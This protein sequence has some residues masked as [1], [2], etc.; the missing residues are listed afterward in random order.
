MGRNP[1]DFLQH[2]SAAD[3]RTLQCLIGYTY[4]QE[5][6]FGVTSS[7]ASSTNRSGL[8][9]V[10][11]STES[12]LHFSITSDSWPNS[13]SLTEDNGM[14]SVVPPAHIQ[15]NFGRRQHQQDVIC[16]TF[17]RPKPAAV[18]TSPLSR[19]NS[20]VDQAIDELMRDLDSYMEIHW[21]AV[22]L[23]V[24]TQQKLADL[25]NSRDDL[26]R[27]GAGL[28]SCRQNEMN[29]DIEPQHRDAYYQA[30]ELGPIEDEYRTL[31]LSLYKIE[32]SLAV[33]NVAIQRKYRSIRPDYPKPLSEV[34]DHRSESH[35]SFQTSPPMSE[36]QILS[37]KSNRTSLLDAECPRERREICQSNLVASPVYS[38]VERM[39]SK[40]VHVDD[41][42][43]DPSP[44]LTYNS[45]DPEGARPS[46]TEVFEDFISRPDPGE[47]LPDKAKVL[48]LDDHQPLSISSDLG[49]TKQMIN[50]WLLHKLRS[51]E[52]ELL[53][54]K[55]MLPPEIKDNEEWTMTMLDTWDTDAA[56]DPPS[57]AEY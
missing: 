32:D 5:H 21:D 33:K 6:Q 1:V 14:P 3:I 34:D 4:D 29:K 51:S 15:S 38:A 55:K 28:D 2:V 57:H 47:T 56:A 36:V 13:P 23:R 17:H 39:D 44:P 16:D 22:P 26:L 48:L 43:P 27:R 24:Q 9:L 45:R 37:Y 50:R 46:F 12:G 53:L 19:R 20:T 40:T 35:F 11:K 18:I 31:A 49:N 10:R 30:R 52:W 25:I 54:F 8:E 7:Q 42:M 41:A